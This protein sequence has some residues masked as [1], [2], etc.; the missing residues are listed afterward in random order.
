MSEGAQRIV[1][2][3]YKQ[4]DFQTSKGLA[5]GQLLNLRH[6][7]PRKKSREVSG[8]FPIN[9]NIFWAE[10]QYFIGLSFI[11]PVAFDTPGIG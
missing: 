10:S 1:I 5:C 4:D 3:R 8:L 6:G 11:K 9:S 2:I 7:L